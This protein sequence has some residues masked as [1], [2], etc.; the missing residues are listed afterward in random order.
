MIKSFF[1]VYVRDMNN[2]LKNFQVPSYQKIFA[3][4]TVSQHCK[5]HLTLTAQTLVVASELTMVR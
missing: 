1:V 2:A 4:V 3:H 5:Q